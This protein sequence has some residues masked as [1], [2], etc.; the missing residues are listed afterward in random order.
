MANLLKRVEILEHKVGALEELPARVDALS[1]QILHLRAEM[2][3]EFSAVRVEM[4]AGDEETRALIKATE[5][6]LREAIGA[7]DEETRALMTVLNQETRTHM[8][9]LHEQLVERIKWLGEGE[10]ASPPG[11]ARTS[12][13]KGTTKKPRR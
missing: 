1:S 7:G 11:G 5:A 3:E 4:K 8:L 12:R 6:E 2:R 10:S 13:R 9:V